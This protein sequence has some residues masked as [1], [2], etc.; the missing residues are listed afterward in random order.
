MQ[1]A[2]QQFAL[3]H[4]SGQ[5]FD[6][7]AG[8]NQGLIVLLHAPY[9]TEGFFGGGDIVDAART[10]A[11]LEGVEEQL[12]KLGR[13]DFAHMQQVDKQRAEGLQALLAGGAQRDQGQV[14]RNR[15]VPTDQQAAQLFGF[16]LVGLD[17]F[18]FQRVEQLALTQAGAVLLVV[19]QIKCAL[20]G[21]ELV[22]EAAARAAA[23][24]TSSSP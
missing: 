5:G 19:L 10:Q 20:I 6:Q 14:Q 1:L 17:A 22:T 24:V 13:G 8:S 21:E 3:G 23:S 4:A 15:G 11:V 2:A 7:G 16:Q 9:I 18:A 12:L